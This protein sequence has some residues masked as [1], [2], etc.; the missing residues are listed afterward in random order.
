MCR[1]CN[2][3]SM[4][5]FKPIFRKKNLKNA[6]VLGNMRS[7]LRTALGECGDLMKCK[8]VTNHRLFRFLIWPLDIAYPLH[9]PLLSK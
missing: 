9:F 1:F 2:I 4:L 8:S 3:F 6:N 5:P 7:G